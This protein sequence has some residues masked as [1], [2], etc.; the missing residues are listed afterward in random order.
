MEVT[1]PDSVM[2]N[3][4]FRVQESTR[5]NLN[6]TLDRIAPNRI[7]PSRPWVDLTTL[8]FSART[9]KLKL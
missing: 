9:L 2:V 7:E 4:E 8:G 3:S 1:N 5:I 6:P